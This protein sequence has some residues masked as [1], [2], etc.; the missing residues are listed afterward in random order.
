[1][2]CDLLCAV[3]VLCVICLVC[4]LYVVCIV[5]DMLYCLLDI[6]GVCAVL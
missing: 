2:V 3:C 6:S 4:V 5:Y 1:M